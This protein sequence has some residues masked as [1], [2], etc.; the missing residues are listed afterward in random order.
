MHYILINCCEEKWKVNIL[1][2][3]LYWI[4]IS[5]WSCFLLPNTT[6]YFMDLFP[7]ITL[8]L[9]IFKLA[10]TTSIQTGSLKNEKIEHE[11]IYQLANA[12]SI[13]RLIP[14]L[15]S[16]ILCARVWESRWILFTLEKSE[17]LGSPVLKLTGPFGS[18]HQTCHGKTAMSWCKRRRGFASVNIFFQ[19]WQLMSIWLGLCTVHRVSSNKPTGVFLFF[20]EFAVRWITISL[21]PLTA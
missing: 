6:Y 20:W 18:N 9:S 11:N 8:W 19:G 10:K 14:G 13:S 5:H 2:G 7:E 17:M 15:W 12:C 4:K 21:C 16:H 3:F 1:T